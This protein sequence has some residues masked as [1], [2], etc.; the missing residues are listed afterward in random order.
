MN[1]I[2]PILI[3]S[4]AALTGCVNWNSF[5]ASDTQ[6]VAKP[7]TTVAAAAQ[8]TATPKAQ[9]KA[10]PVPTAKATPAASP[11]KTPAAQASPV[12]TPKP[13]S[14]VI[15]EEKTSEV[16]VISSRPVVGTDAQMGQ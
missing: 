12:A 8:P 9:A 13:A 11:A 10:T 15:K 7:A 3:L 4:V 16:K 6:S 14:A 1:T 2:K 5:N